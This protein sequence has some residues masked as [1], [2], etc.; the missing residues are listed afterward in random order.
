MEWTQMGRHAAQLLFG[1]KFSAA[2][3][4]YFHEACKKSRMCVASKSFACASRRLTLGW[5]HES[6]I[7]TIVF[8]AVFVGVEYRRSSTFVCR[9]KSGWSAK[10]AG[11]LQR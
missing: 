3:G 4:C 6:T 9:E 8:W 1:A 10:I 7:A 5:G 2:N 11:R